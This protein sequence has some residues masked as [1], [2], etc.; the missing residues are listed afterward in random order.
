MIG[1]SWRGC[2][3]VLAHHHVQVC[4]TI[5]GVGFQVFTGAG[6]RFRVMGDSAMDDGVGGDPYLEQIWAYFQTVS[7][8][9]VSQ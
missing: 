8:W 9:F 6:F 1:V 2:L 3:T 5:P 4:S 7:W